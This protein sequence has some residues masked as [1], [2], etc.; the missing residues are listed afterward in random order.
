MLIFQ[1][2]TIGI[3]ELVPKNLGVELKVV[4]HENREDRHL[5]IPA[6]AWFPLYFYT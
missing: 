5:G 3:D 4:L 2:E 6:Y 1:A